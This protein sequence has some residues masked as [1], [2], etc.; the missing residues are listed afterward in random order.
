M[1]KRKQLVRKP[2]MADS[3]PEVSKVASSI[4]PKNLKQIHESWRC[5]ASA[6]LVIWARAKIGR[7]LG[8]EVDER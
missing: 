2:R 8:K 5:M 4:M 3:H 6:L 7:H 1:T